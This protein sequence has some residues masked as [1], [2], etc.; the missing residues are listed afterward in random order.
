MLKSARESKAVTSWMNPNA[1]YEAAL[2]AFVQ[3][4]LARREGN[5]FL[6][7]LQR[8]RRGASPGTA[9]STA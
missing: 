7:D 5:L 8:E 1:A 3:A 2:S 6:D 4:L 9:R